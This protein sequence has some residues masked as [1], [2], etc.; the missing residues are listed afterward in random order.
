MQTT[1]TLFQG[2]SRF[3]LSVSNKEGITIVSENELLG[4]LAQTGDAGKEQRLKSIDRFN[5]VNNRVLDEMLRLSNASLFPTVEQNG[6]PAAVVIGDSDRHMADLRWTALYNV[7]DYRTSPLPVFKIMD[8]YNVVQFDEYQQ[9][10]RI[11]LGYVRGE[12]KL[13]EPVI[14]AGG[15]Q[16]NDLWAGWNGGMWNRQDGLSAM[17]T[18]YLNRQ[19]KAA[20]TVATADGLDVV[21][22]PTT[23][24]ASML[25]KDVEAINTACSEI[26]NSFFQTQNDPGNPDSQETEEEIEGQTFVLLYNPA[27]PGYRTRVNRAINASYA[28]QNDNNSGAQLDFNIVPIPSRYVPVNGWYLFLPGRKLV[29]AIFKALQ[30]YD[31]NDPRIAGVAKG[32]VGQGAYGIVRGDVRQGRKINTQ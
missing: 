5:T 24:G 23:A 18:R 31:I 13:Y 12:S 15:L 7:Q 27:T 6:I 11:K 4:M 16:W 9:G 26:G 3:D 17:A 29:A 30:M 21:A 28:A 1:T 25:E 10:E 8:T 22:Y 19:A 20:Y 32:E 14:V 2:N